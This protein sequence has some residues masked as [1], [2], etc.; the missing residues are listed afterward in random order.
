[1]EK[2][3]RKKTEA[4]KWR[5]ELRIIKSIFAF[6]SN[7]CWHCS[8]CKILYEKEDAVMF[9]EDIKGKRTYEIHCPKCDYSMAGGSTEYFNDNYIFEKK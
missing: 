1:M 7:E 4:E 9:W 5:K 6:S 2:I 3:I 8:S